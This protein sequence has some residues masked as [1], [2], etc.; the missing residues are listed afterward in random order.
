MLSLQVHLLMILPAT[1]HSQVAYGTHTP[2]CLRAEHCSPSPF[3]WWFSQS[4]TMSL[5]SRFLSRSHVG[6][7]IIK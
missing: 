5:H 4:N 7:Q 1:R 3:Q 2:P 6:G